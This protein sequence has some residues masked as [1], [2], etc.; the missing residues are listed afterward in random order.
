MEKVFAQV[1]HS[2]WVAICPFCQAMGIVSAVEVAAGDAVFVCPEEY[3]GTQANMLIPHA[4]RKGAF[5]S[6]PDDDTRT[7]ARQTAI[8]AEKA[9]EIV[10]PA[11]KAE[12]ERVL[13]YRPRAARNWYPGVS[14]EELK[15]ENERMGVTHD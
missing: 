7:Q 3:P 10:Y 12:I 4:R 9:Y 15:A 14:L 11:E 1:N 13:R 6:V 5:V 2:R 8:A